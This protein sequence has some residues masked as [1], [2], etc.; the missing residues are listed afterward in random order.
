MR[1]D[2]VFRGESPEF[3]KTQIIYRKEKF[4]ADG[5]SEGRARGLWTEG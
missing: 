3:L 1:P 2:I 5:T 4:G